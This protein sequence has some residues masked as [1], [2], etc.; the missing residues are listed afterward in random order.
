MGKNSEKPSQKRS[1][2]NRKAATRRIRL[3]LRIEVSLTTKD[4]ALA[5]D[6][7]DTWSTRRRRERERKKNE[8]AGSAKHEDE[9]GR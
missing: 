6:A 4:P 9:C 1:H 7:P 3:Y 2:E 5:R 8:D